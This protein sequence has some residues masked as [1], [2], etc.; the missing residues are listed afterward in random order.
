[1]RLLIEDL[2][3]AAGVHAESAGEPVLSLAE[4]SRKL[5]VSTKTISRWRQR[6]LVSRRF[7]FEGQTKVGFLQSS[8]DRFVSSN[9]MRVRRGARFRQVSADERKNIIERARRLAL[10]FGSGQASG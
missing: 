9:E 6:G 10:S 8:V 4:L 3:E 5:G 1:L 2:S 7:N